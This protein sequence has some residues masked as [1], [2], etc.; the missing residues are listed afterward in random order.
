MESYIAEFL[1]GTSATRS[2]QLDQFVSI[3]FLE[4]SLTFHFSLFFTSILIISTVFAKIRTITVFSMHPVFMTLGS[5]IFIGEGLC[6]FRNRF[7]VDTFSPIMSKAKRSKVRTIHI[8]MN[9]FGFACLCIGM[10]FVLTNKIEF[11]MSLVPATIHEVFGLLTFTWVRSTPYHLRPYAQITI[12]VQIIVQVVAG[13]QKISEMESKS[14][15]NTRI[16]R[17]DDSS[18]SLESIFFHRERHL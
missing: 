18:W 10:L 2:R 8:T 1:A 15:S 12:I 17:F 7:L 5:I 11:N 6:S 3:A 16:R 9:C 14:H 13:F 4:A